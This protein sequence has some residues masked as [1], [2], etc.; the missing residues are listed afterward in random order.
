MTSA[1]EDPRVEERSIGRLFGVTDGVFA[2]AMTL[3]VIDVRVPDFADDATTRTVARALYEQ[4]PSYLSFL[5]SF[6]VIANYWRRHHREMRAVAVA[7]PAMIRRTFVLLLAVTAMPFAASLLARHGDAAG[8]AATVY[9]AVN[10]V[11]IVALLA[12]RAEAMRDTRSAGSLR[13]RSTE[14]LL[15]LV[16]YLV[17]VPVAFLLPRHGI[18]TLFIALGVS[19]V[20]HRVITHR[21]GGRTSPT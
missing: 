9:A 1:P 16:A 18:E 20:V 17:A 15:D 2:I 13:R 21:L 6:Y 14:L 10:I 19:G 4:M 8:V 5:I 12:I 3:L 11:A 7:T